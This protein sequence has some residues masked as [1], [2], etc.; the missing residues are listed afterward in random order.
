MFF[1]KRKRSK[2]QRIFLG[3]LAA[4]L[5]FGLLASS[6][7]W[8]GLGG[9]NDQIATPTGNEDRIKNLEEQVKQTPDDKVLL[10]SLAYYYTQAGKVDKASETYQ[11]VV[12]LDPKNI[13][14]HQNLALLYY[15]Q[16]QLEASEQA[17]KSALDVEPANAEVNYQYAKLLAEKQDYQTAISH[18]EKFLAAQS[19]GSKAE[20]ARKSIET[21]QKEAGQ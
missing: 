12:K 9:S 6:I 11:K 7:A 1:R 17:L 15:S 10:N 16:G 21:W 2:G 18:M 20:E 3:V 5:S 8:T 4:I 13:S 14:A 19:E